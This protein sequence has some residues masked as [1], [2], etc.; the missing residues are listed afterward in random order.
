M[1]FIMSIEPCVMIEK[2]IKKIYLNW[3]LH[4][5]WKHFSDAIK[6]GKRVILSEYCISSVLKKAE[7]YGEVSLLHYRI[8]GRLLKSLKETLFCHNLIPSLS[9][10]LLSIFIA[11]FIYS[12][13]MLLF[14][15]QL[16]KHLS[17]TC[18]IDS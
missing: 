2:N 5:L 12:E 8:L 16:M 7:A 15:K 6:L 17:C 3:G 9:L 13:F 10:Q 4:Q 18:Y 14:L 11:I 1:V